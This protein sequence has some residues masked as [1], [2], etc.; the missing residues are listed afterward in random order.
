MQLLF[1]IRFVRS[2]PEDLSYPRR[3]VILLITSN[4]WMR[5]F[6]ASGIGKDFHSRNTFILR[7]R[8]RDCP[9]PHAD[10]S[11]YDCVDSNLSRDRYYICGLRFTLTPSRGCLCFHRLRSQYLRCSERSSIFSMFSNNPL[12]RTKSAFTA[13]HVLDICPGTIQSWQRKLHS[14]FAIPIRDKAAV[15]IQASRPPD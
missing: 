9:A 14:N 3:N 12:N 1:T 15:L 13:A 6:R 11:D 10:Q 7:S 5:N 2:F 8:L 4:G